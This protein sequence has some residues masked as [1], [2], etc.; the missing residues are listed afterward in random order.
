[1]DKWT[2]DVQVDSLQAY[3]MRTRLSNRPD[4]RPDMSNGQLDNGRPRGR[5]ERCLDRVQI[6]YSDMWTGIWRRL[7][8]NKFASMVGSDERQN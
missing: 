1:M 5:N 8:H 7:C 4:N 3:L 2:M 6:V